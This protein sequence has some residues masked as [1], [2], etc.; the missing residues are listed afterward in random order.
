[1]MEA[2]GAGPTVTVLTAT[3]DRAHT[4]PRLYESL[5]RQTCQDLEWLVVDDGSTD[6]TRALVEDWQRAGAPFPIRYVHKE[7]GGKH[8]AH[9][10]G[11]QRARG[12]Y[13]AII[14]SDDWYPPEAIARLL[15]HWRAMGE[16]ERERFA[17]VEGLTC[18]RDGKVI[19]SPFP[20]P[21]FDSDTVWIQVQRRVP[22]DTR[23][24]YRTAVLKEFPFPEPPGCRFVPE[25]LVWNRVAARYR[26]RFVNEVTGFT[27]YQAGGLSARPAADRLESPL[28]LQYHAE[29]L[30]RPGRL[31]CRIGLRSAVNHARL[32]FHQGMGPW[33]QLA[34][35]GRRGLRLAAL[36]AGWVLWVIDRRRALREDPGKPAR[37][38]RGQDSSPDDR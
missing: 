3:F 35:P 9:N 19:G 21:V 17:D 26:T 5:L 30:A 34:G 10:L 32:S 6:G 33:R 20:A 18:G 1:M 27:E 36:P 2:Y 31:P 37:A 38:G 25:G 4:L 28:T 11:V 24:M 22:G 8:T 7:N 14:D 16:G 15:G 29:L 13:L 12:E 23:G